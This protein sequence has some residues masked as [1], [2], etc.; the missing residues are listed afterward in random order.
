MTESSRGTEGS[1]G[2]ES[3][4]EDWG[5]ERELRVSYHFIMEERMKQ[6]ILVAGASRGIGAELVEHFLT[7]GN[8]VLAIIRTDNEHVQKIRAAH[9]DDF[10]VLYADIRDEEALKTAA[11]KAAG[12]CGD[13]GIDILITN[14]AV[15]LEQPVPPDIA[16][17]DFDAIEET[18]R[19]NSIGPLKV[20]KHFLE[21][22][23]KG[24]KKLIV[25]ISSE[26]GSI[27]DCTRKSEYGYCM[28][29]SALN[30]ATKILS[31]RL[32][33]EDIHLLAVHPGWVRTDMGGQN[34]HL[35][36][37]ESVQ[38]IAAL[39]KKTWKRD[40]PV[41]LDYTGKVMNW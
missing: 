34:A 37:A 18:L 1:R 26:A 35:S 11:Q 14:A 2:T 27:G 8:R 15:H 31:N 20:I 32:K 19:V 24:K 36:T 16:D 6:T 10:S 13:G 5:A 28:S 25:N 9:P 30:M 22:V 40:D 3:S 17:I 4:R 29:K 38:G 41:Y 33:D 23:R 7:E 39:L 21:L 12:L